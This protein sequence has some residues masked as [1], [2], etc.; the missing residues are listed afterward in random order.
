MPGD[1]DDVVLTPAEV[2]AVLSKLCSKLGFCLPPKEC[3]RFRTSPPRDV[4][5]FS[6]EVFRAEGLEPNRA[7]THLWR[8]V[9]DVVA[10]AF[11][12]HGAPED[13][14]RRCSQPPTRVRPRFP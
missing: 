1:S 6:N 5:E 2:D 14:T 10:E 8:Q 4:R 12:A 11:E 9:R 3:Q 7:D 13:L